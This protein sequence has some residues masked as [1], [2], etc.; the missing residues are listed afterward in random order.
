MNEKPILFSGEM[1]RAILDGRK[2]QTRR[3]VQF[4]RYW[5]AQG[6]E[7]KDLVK[8]G[9]WIAYS[10]KEQRH[11]WQYGDDQLPQQYHVGDRLW[12][13][14]TWVVHPT[15][16]RVKPSDLP[17]DCNVH[18]RADPDF[19]ESHFMASRI[20]LEIVSVRVE[21]VNNISENDAIA[22][23]TTPSIVGHDLD[24]LKYRAGFQTLW[25]SINAKR[26][27]DWDVNPWVWVIEFKR[28]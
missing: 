27:F 16:N 12:V 7:H 19:N 14:E 4:P 6:I 26:G 17:H 2:S 11:F 24:Y 25:N 3:V 13:R 9:F 10:D 20:T 21:R 18:Y 15:L 1:V 5:K 22:E 23:G 8:S 28:K